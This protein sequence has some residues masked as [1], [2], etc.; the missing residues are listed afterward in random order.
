MSIPLSPEDVA[1]LEGR[2]CDR[3]NFHPEDRKEPRMA[4]TDFQWRIGME[5]ES[6]DDSMTGKGTGDAPLVL[7]ATM[8]IGSMS[9]HVE[10]YLV[11]YISGG[12]HRRKPN[13]RD[14]ETIELRRNDEVTGWLW[15]AH[16]MEGYCETVKIP[17]VGKNR[18]YTIF[19]S[20][21][22]T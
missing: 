19:M 12:K 1:R 9:L 17:G 15:Q 6:D 2:P 10:A 8:Q 22:C 20:P 5:P 3:Y 13:W 18:E 7:V 16:G 4:V 14:N 11:E 21:F